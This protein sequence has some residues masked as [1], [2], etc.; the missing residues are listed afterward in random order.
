MKIKISFVLLIVF[1]AATVGIGVSTFLI[2]ALPQVAILGILA[3][4]G[5][6]SIFNRIAIENQ[7]MFSDD[8]T[9]G[10]IAAKK[11]EEKESKRVQEEDVKKVLQVIS[12]GLRKGQEKETIASSLVEMGYPG[13]L[14]NWA[15]EHEEIKKLEKE[16]QEEAQKKAEAAASKGESKVIKITKKPGEKKK[17]VKGTKPGGAE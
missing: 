3:A 1:V 2:G 6:I 12:L 5:M 9:K 7:Q 11:E 14:I 16:L 10:F 15:M 4:L 8:F 13:E 17:K